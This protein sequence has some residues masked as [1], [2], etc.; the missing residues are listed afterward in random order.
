MNTVT[1]YQDAHDVVNGSLQEVLEKLVA[2]IWYFP[3]K[4]SKD[5]SEFKILEIGRMLEGT[6]IPHDGNPNYPTIGFEVKV[7]CMYNF[8]EE[9]TTECGF[10]AVWTGSKNPYDPFEFEE[11]DQKELGESLHFRNIYGDKFEVTNVLKSKS[12]IEEFIKLIK[13]DP[14]AV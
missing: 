9:P 8:D 11:G 13:F 14:N 1:L 3:K 2:N 5:Y 6:A 7:K 10:Y 4:N 12:E